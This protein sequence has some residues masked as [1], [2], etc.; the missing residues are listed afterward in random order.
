MHPVFDRQTLNLDSALGALLSEPGTEMGY[1]CR[2]VA[3]NVMH[4]PRVSRRRE[5]AFRQ[6]TVREPELTNALVEYYNQHVRTAAWAHFLDPLCNQ[7]NFVAGARTT[8]DLIDSDIPLMRVVNLNRERAAFQWGVDH[9]ADPGKSLFRDIANALSEDQL[10]EAIGRRLQ[11]DAEEFLQ[12]WFRMLS[13][14]REA[15]RALG[16]GAAEG[17]VWVT[18]AKQFLH[19]VDPAKEGP[20]RWFEFVGVHLETGPVWAILLSYHLS[21]AGTV[22]R[23]TILDAGGYPYHF[24]SPQQ[25]A[26]ADGGFVMDLR[27]DPA[28]ECLRNEFV[29]E[30][31]DFKF[32]HWVA[33]GRHLGET[34]GPGS[35]GID[36][37]RQ[38]HHELLDR[39][40]AGVKSWMPTCV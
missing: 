5:E 30:A 3:R 7:N 40:Y 36:R 24:P 9:W 19:D 8:V 28:S 27:T 4:D 21:E 14:R 37:Q 18:F 33:A 23:P 2:A 17:P 35:S 11:D 34:S 16:R 22:A 26:L 20:D 38:I 13:A 39:R 6:W 12:A 10:H 29:H 31:I 25:A 1:R 32:E 15:L